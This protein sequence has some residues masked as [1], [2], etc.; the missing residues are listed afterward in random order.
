M[1]IHLG[2]GGEAHLKKEW[3]EYMHGVQM[4]AGSSLFGQRL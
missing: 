2:G 3:G 1:R 4:N